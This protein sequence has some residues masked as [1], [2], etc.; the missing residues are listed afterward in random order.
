MPS[1][2]IIDM[3]KK[4]IELRDKVS[5]AKAIY[6]EIKQQKDDHELNMYQQME[7]EGV[8]NF[9]L[10]G[11]GTFYKSARPYA[12]VEDMEKAR[13]FFTSVG[14]H[15]EIFQLKAKAA[16][17]NEFVKENYIEKSLPIPEEEMGV[18]VI[19]GIRGRK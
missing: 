1:T 7:I 18:G 9:K 8:P 19:I 11:I 12:S 6:E 10:E 17:M 14:I 15:D 4:A 13:A 5:E 2:Q 16:R 3:A